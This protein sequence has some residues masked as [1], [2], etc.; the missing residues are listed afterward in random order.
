MATIK[1]KALQVFYQPPEPDRAMPKSPSVGHSSVPE[2]QL[3]GVTDRL[4][5]RN[6]CNPQ[7]NPLP[8]ARPWHQR[9]R[10]KAAGAHRRVDAVNYAGTFG[11]WEYQVCRNVDSLR[12]LIDMVVSTKMT[13][14]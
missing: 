3:S 13:E 10:A 12:T 2:H 9:D 7:H 5:R 8:A 1:T 4:P 14:A 11:R 6:P